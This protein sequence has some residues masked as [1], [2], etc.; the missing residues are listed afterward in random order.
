MQFTKPLEGVLPGGDVNVTD[1]DGDTPLYT[2][3]NVE[4]AQFLIAHGAVVDRRNNAG[5]SVRRT[6]FWYQHPT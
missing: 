4:T 3:E 5:I 2:V 1:C 6:I